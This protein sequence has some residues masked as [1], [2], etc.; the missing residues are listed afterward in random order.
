MAV[1]HAICSNI[2]DTVRYSAAKQTDV[3]RTEVLQSE[4]YKDFQALF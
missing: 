1:W 4:V 2:A 3:L